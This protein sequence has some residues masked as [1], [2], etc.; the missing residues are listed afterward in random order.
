MLF[1]GACR[2]R[3]SSVRTICPIC[4]S[5]VTSVVTG[6][7]RGALGLGFGFFGTCG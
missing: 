6:M 1:R 2:L 5:L 7:R 3:Q 4:V